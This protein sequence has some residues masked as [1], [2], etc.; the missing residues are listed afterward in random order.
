[1]TNVSESAK[2]YISLVEIFLGHKAKLKIACKKVFTSH[3]LED[4]ETFYRHINEANASIENNHHNGL[5]MCDGNNLH[6]M[7]HLLHKYMIIADEKKE[8]LDGL[9]NKLDMEL[10]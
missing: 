9:I 4:Y 1:M 5:C 3:S 7:V 6:T 8:E 2:Q 10:C